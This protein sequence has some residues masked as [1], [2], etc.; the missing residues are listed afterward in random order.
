[1]TLIQPR[2][3]ARHCACDRLHP[4]VE[5]PEPAVDSLRQP[6]H[7]GDGVHRALCADGGAK[8]QDLC[9]VHVTNPARSGGDLWRDQGPSVLAGDAAAARAGHLRWLA[10]RVLRG[11]PRAGDVLAHPSD[12]HQLAR[13]VDHEPIR[14]RPPRRGN[15]DDID[16]RRHLHGR[17]GP[18]PLV[19]GASWPLVALRQG[20]ELAQDAVHLAGFDQ[21]RVVADGG[22]QLRHGQQVTQIA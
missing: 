19:A 16:R 6:T 5:L 21:E 17:T 11:H 18:H 13:A 2:H 3:R 8:H 14:T 22:R 20:D 4:A 12:Q 1:M 10:A 9:R 7:P 15:G